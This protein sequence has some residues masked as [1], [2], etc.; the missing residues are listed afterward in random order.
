MRILIV[1]DNPADRELLVFALQEHFKSEAKFREV[2]SLEDAHEYLKRGPVD[3]IVLDL[4]L[5][6]SSGLE[7][8]TRI[9]M[10]YP[11]V[12]IVIVS[13][14]VNMTLAKDMIRTG[15]EDFILK[16]YTST[17][18]LFRRIV[19]AIERVKRNQ[20]RLMTD[21]PPDDTPRVANT[22]PPEGAVEDPP[23]TLPSGGVGA[24]DQT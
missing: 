10:A 4:G 12:P 23:D 19:F 8:F 16:D 7:T 17:T 2:S 5:P 15:A 18:M 22:S 3:C 1:E 13:N 24:D 6:D 20:R 11:H 21:P 14:T 9:Y